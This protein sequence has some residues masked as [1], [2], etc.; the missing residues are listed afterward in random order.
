MHEPMEK[1]DSLLSTTKPAESS[2]KPVVVGFWF[3]LLADSL[4]VLLLGIIG[5]VAVFLLQDLLYEIG[6]QGW[7]I[8]LCITFIYTGVL[9]SA[10]GNGQTLAKRF[11]NIQVLKRDGSFMSLQE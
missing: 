9:Q 1:D 10:I 2:D 6:E 7:W 5:F 3:R 4:D 8:G 11:L